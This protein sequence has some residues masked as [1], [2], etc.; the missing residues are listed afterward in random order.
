MAGRKGNQKP[1]QQNEQEWTYV[2]E[3]AKIIIMTTCSRREHIQNV[4]EAVR[5][6]KMVD[7]TY[8]LNCPL[9][10]K[11]IDKYTCF[12]IHMVVSGTSPKSEAPAEIYNFMDYEDICYS[13]RY[14]RYD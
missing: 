8:P 11:E 12:S 4:P 1:T 6:L 13:C 7:F 2:G 9:T 3:N 5:D 10:G 14:H